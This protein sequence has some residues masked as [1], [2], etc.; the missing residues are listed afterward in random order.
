MVA[1]QAAE[2]YSEGLTFERIAARLGCTTSAA[3]EGTMAVLDLVHCPRCGMLM[4]SCQARCS[5]CQR[6]TR[7]ITDA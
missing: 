1:Q 7:R 4:P 2:L 6:E 5:D 3:I